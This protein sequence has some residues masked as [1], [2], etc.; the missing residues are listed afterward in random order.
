MS[1]REN[2]NFTRCSPID[3][4]YEDRKLH[5]DGILDSLM[6]YKEWFHYMGTFFVNENRLT[7]VVG[8]PSYLC[9][10]GA[11]GWISF[12]KKQYSFAG[13]PQIPGHYGFFDLTVHAEFN[14][15]KNG[16]LIEYP[17]AS[18]NSGYTGHVNGKFPDYTI[19]VTT[20]ELE[21]TISM[22]I[23]SPKE[24]VYTRNLCPWLI[25]GWFHSG[26]VTCLLEGTINGQN[27]GPVK[28]R[29]WYER[30]WAHIPLPPASWFWFMTHLE[31]GDVFDLL[32]E[33]SMG[34]RIHYLDECWLY[35]NRTFCE[36]P[37]YEATIPE[38]VKRAIQKRDYSQI[39]EK[40]ITCRGRTNTET[41][42]VTA[43]I[44]DFRQYEFCNCCASI[45]WANFIIETEGEAHINGKD[46]D[47]KGW[48]AAEYAPILYWWC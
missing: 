5:N 24:S 17:K 4:P 35:Q 29:G 18:P 6:G 40:K 39:I 38:K 26:D 22:H 42:N 31:N 30:N 3:V 27:L 8:F 36:I 45:K 15:S 12:N 44:T 20:P 14:K 21:V 16:Y 28:G 34:I 9:G 32:V 48:G 19:T 37:Y 7:F 2:K 13:N 10:M 11:L 1:A 46:I 41:F 23:N 25:G 43:T 47:M 33:K